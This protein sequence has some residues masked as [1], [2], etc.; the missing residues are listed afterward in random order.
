M[1]PDPAPT[2]SL[3]VFV[4][5]GTV[6]GANTELHDVRFA[7]GA[8]VEACLPEIRAQWWGTPGSLHLDAWGRLDWADGYGLRVSDIPQEPGE[9]ALWF[10]NM[11]GYVPGEFGEA[12]RNLFVIARDAAEAKARGLKLCRGWARQ[13]HRDYAFD[14]DAL[15]RVG[16]TLGLHRHVQVSPDPNE[17]PFQFETG[18]WPVKRWP[19]V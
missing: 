3:W 16:D 4:V 10:V 9:P 7:T 6:K 17:R 2:L 19:K 1:T 15:I 12:H 8:S 18:Y 5:G 13:V 14:V 11:G